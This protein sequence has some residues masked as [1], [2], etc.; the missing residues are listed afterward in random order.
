M[1]K[2]IKADFDDNTIVEKIIDILN[3]EKLLNDDK[4]ELVILIG[5]VDLVFQLYHKK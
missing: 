2:M 5:G 4:N 3:Q 1:V